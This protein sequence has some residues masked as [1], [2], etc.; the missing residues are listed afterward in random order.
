MER[1]ILKKEEE[2]V[3]LLDRCGSEEEGMGKALAVR[4]KRAGVEELEEA[5]PSK[6][7][8]NWKKV[9]RLYR[10]KTGVGCDG[11]T[12]KSPPGCDKRKERRNSGVLGKGE[13]E[14]K[15]AA[16]SMHDDVLLDP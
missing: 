14:W 12:P 7:R 6:K 13:A 15:L 4:R 5:L 3:R 8:A 2:D 9:S 10:A 16:T 11:F 1:R